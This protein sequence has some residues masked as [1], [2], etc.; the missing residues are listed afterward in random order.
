MNDII[1]IKGTTLTIYPSTDK[2]IQKKQSK[3]IRAWIK[4]FKLNKRRAKR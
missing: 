4:S 1:E 2:K 3:V